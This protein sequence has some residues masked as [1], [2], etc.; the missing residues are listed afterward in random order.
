MIRKNIFLLLLFV[1]AIVYSSTMRE[2]RAVWLTTNF[3]L[4]WPPKTFDEEIQKARLEE[5]F[6]N[7]KNKKFN[8]IYFQVR[9]NG[10]INYYS[11]NEPFSAYFKGEVGK[12]PNYDPLAYAI[13]LGKKYFIEVHAWVNTIRAYAGKDARVLEH[14]KHLSNTHPEFLV[15][16]I[17]PNG[18]ISY[19]LNPSDTN[20][21]D[22]LVDILLDISSRYDIDGIHLDFFRYPNKNFDDELSYLESESNLSRDDWRRNN[23]TTILRKFNEKKNPLNPYLKVGATPIG[24]RKMLKG[25]KGMEGFSE[26]YQDTET[27]L[28]E[29]LVDYLT[30]QIYWNFTDNPHFDILADDWV[31]KSYGKNIVLGLSAYHNEVIPELELMIE[32]SRKI[33][34]A[35][36][37]FF[38]YEHIASEENNFF[39]EIAFPSNMVWKSKLY[40]QPNDKIIADYQVVSDDMILITWQDTVKNKSDFRNYVLLNDAEPIKILS[41]ESNQLKLK[42]GNPAKLKYKYYLSKIDRLWNYTNLSNPIDVAVPYLNE[43]KQSSKLY[44]RPLLFEENKAGSYITMRSAINQNILLD[45]ISRE[46]LRYQKMFKVKSGFNVIPLKVSSKFLR[47]IRITFINSGLVEEINFY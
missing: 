37:S 41:K 11:D 18:D 25:A 1:N 13:E 21:Q 12:V 34:A 16:S 14:P 33:R 42:F 10:A 43:L 36:I 40:Y 20:A 15:E 23:L 26:V 31:N 35:G 29:G 2:T 19:W 44:R 4:D 46:N 28:E 32:Y 17:L 30:P 45:I 39:S 38:R 9:S 5:I 22:Y 27:W 7:L 47:S 24:I 6:K 8:T 3:Q